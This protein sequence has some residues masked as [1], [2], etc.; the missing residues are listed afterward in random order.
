MRIA[1]PP[2][3]LPH[4]AYNRIAL[5]YERRIFGYSALIIEAGIVYLF[6]KLGAL[7]MQGSGGVQLGTFHYI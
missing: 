1:V 4:Y 7:I 3:R 5:K 6:A 2:R